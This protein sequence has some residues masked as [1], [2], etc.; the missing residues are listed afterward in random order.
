MKVT[1]NVECT[2]EEARSFMGLPDVQP[3][4]ERLMA[5]LESRLNANIAAMSPENMVKTW[6]P[7]GLQ[8]AD[9][10][11]KMFWNQLQQM[12]AGVVGTTNAMVTVKERD[13]ASS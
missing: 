1:V 4:Q 11:Q 6:L 3:M 12:V 13:S 7:A 9:H 10:L 8:G 2:P 5:E